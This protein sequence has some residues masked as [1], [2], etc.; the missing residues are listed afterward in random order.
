MQVSPRRRT[1]E[2]TRAEILNTAIEVVAEKGPLGLTMDAV[3]ERLSFSKG[4]LLHQFPS[5]TALL[6]GMIDRLGESF[7]A[8]IEE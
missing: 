2:A 8:Q 3:V 1:P 4:A 6:E 5:Q 7:V